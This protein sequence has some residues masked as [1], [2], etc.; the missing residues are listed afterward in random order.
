MDYPWYAIL[1]TCLVFVAL[2]IAVVLCIRWGVCAYHVHPRNGKPSK[3]RKHL[4]QSMQ[5]ALT[6]LE[7]VTEKRP[8]RN[9]ETEAADA[10]CPICLTHLYPSEREAPV[11]N[12]NEKGLR[13][14]EAGV[15]VPGTAKTPHDKR[16]SMTQPIDDERLKMK[17]CRHVFHARC[18]ATWFLRKQYRCPVCRTPYYQ[19]VEEMEADIDYRLQPPPPVVP[20]W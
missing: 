9:P 5:Y 14:L 20:F 4:P 12:S 3:S 1:L 19:A 16:Q 10:E 2:V 8:H 15:G 11:P 17:R 7:G 13:D 18:L 6:Q